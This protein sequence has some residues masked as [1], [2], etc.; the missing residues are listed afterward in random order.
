MDVVKCTHK[1]VFVSYLKLFRRSLV[2]QKGR[3][4]FDG[5]YCIDHISGQ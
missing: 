3:N 5:W 1:K 4:W 2:E